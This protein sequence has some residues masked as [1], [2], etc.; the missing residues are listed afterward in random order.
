MFRKS[1]DIMKLVVYSEVD[2]SQ[3]R[4]FVSIQVIKKNTRRYFY[5]ILKSQSFKLLIKRP[6]SKYICKYTKQVRIGDVC[7][8][9]INI[10]YKYNMYDI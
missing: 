7:I 6:L 1:N 8:L 9:T 10:H 2:N 5:I 3:A 4:N